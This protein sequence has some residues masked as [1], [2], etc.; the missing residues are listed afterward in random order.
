MASKDQPVDELTKYD[1]L[2]G[3][4]KGT[5]GDCFR[6]CIATIVQS[7]PI[8]LP[9]PHEKGVWVLEWE[10]WLAKRGL[11]ITFQSGYWYNDGLWVA[12][13]PSQ[14]YKDTTH[15]VVMRGSELYHDPSPK[16]RY[17][18]IN[19][20]KV[21]TSYHIELLDISKLCQAECNRARLQELYDWKNNSPAGREMYVD[22]RIK[23][24]QQLMKEGE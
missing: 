3:G 21:L 4:G 24:L 7:N 20:S 23:K 2:V 22:K 8:E 12:S 18:T 15:A 17:S 1:Q 6:A 16:K 13:V 11:G 5:L 19:T 9:N 10:E 14:N